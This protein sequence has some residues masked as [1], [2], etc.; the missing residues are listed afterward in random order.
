[1]SRV[2]SVLRRADHVV[3]R[4]EAAILSGAVLALAGV[5]IANV[6]ARNALGRSFSSAEEL[7]QICAIA[8]TFVGVG[9]AARIDR[10]IRMSALR[11]ALPPRGRRLLDHAMRAGTG[12][13]LLALAVFAFAYVADTRAVAS[14]TPALRLPL[15]AVYAVVPVG[16]ALGGLQYAL[17]L[18]QGLL[19]PG[20]GSPGATSGEAGA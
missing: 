1:V 2:L 12:G 16:L 15:Y 5:N 20:D 3:A 11:D 17:A 9:Y 14:V 18:V 8:I 19:A 7:S 4:F 13:L 6:V 10:H